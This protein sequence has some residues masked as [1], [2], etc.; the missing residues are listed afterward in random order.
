MRSAKENIEFPYRRS[1]VCYF[2]VYKDG[3]VCQV[4]HKNKCDIE[5]VKRHIVEQKKIL[6]LCMLYGLETGVVTYS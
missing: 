4:P 6:Q 2:E 5:C 1:T 3:K